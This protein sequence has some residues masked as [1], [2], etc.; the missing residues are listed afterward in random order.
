MILKWIWSN[1]FILQKTKIKAKRQLF[2]V[3]S[4]EAERN[5]ICIQGWRSCKTIFHAQLSL[6]QTTAEGLHQVQWTEALPIP[7]GVWE[8]PEQ[9]LLRVWYRTRTRNERFKDCLF[10]WERRIR[11]WGPSTIDHLYIYLT[12]VVP[13]IRNNLGYCK[14]KGEHAPERT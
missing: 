4:T 13:V 1:L 3:L 10:L 5:L 14:Q 9:I 11:R 7:A 12:I 8:T 2:N 6:P